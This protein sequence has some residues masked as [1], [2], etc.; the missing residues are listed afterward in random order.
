MDKSNLTYLLAI[1]KHIQKKLNK[2]EIDKNYLRNQ[3]LNL[4]THFDD[5]DKLTTHWFNYSRN[6]DM[7]ETQKDL[8]ENKLNNLVAMYE[9]IKSSNF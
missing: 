7:D 5:F 3:L 9:K 6:S 2:F 8:I 4:V 1:E